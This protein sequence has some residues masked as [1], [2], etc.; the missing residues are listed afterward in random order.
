MWV[1]NP[2]FWC[3]T[4]FARISHLCPKSRIRVGNAFLSHMGGGGGGVR[5]AVLTLTSIVAQNVY[6]CSTRGG[7]GGTVYVVK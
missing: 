6:D 1:L 2:R 7:G 5:R 3:T 4:S